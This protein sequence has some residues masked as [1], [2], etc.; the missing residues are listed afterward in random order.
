MIDETEGPVTG[1]LLAKR[2]GVT[3]QVIVQDLAILRAA[4]E[5]VVATP[6]GYCRPE[7]VARPGRL[8]RTYVL[9]HS[10]DAAEIEAELTAITDL[11]GRAIDV[12]VE[13]P[14]Y[15][16]LTGSLMI[17]S[18]RDVQDFLQRLATSKA[19]PLLVLC[20]GVH[21]HTIE[22]PDE[23]AHAAIRQALHRLGFLPE[24]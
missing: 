8:Q 11:G 17:G 14:V 19:G 15:G 1:G 12:T 2:F 18:R 21:L 4:G 5:Q 20:E 6:Q 24:S 16:D 13:H 23:A 10:A 22:S 7:A 9:R 3:R